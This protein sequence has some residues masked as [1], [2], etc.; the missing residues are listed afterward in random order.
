MAPM[1]DYPCYAC[2]GGGRR[3]SPLDHSQ[4][5]AWLEARRQ[6]E[7]LAVIGKDLSVRQVAVTLWLQGKRNPSR[8]VLRLCEVLTQRREAG[9]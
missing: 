4:F 3:F 2:A 6:R 5:V 1:R 8:M 7:S 9:C